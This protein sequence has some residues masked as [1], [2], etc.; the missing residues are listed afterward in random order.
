MDG[1]VESGDGPLIHHRA[2]E[3]PSA[4]NV[5]QAGH[6]QL[7]RVSSAHLLLNGEGLVP[8]RHG[9]GQSN[10]VEAIEAGVSVS[11]G[12]LFDGVVDAGHGWK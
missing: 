11:G 7:A 1:P 5:Q 3:V 6:F 2:I 10:G 8:V 12:E 4:G 9:D